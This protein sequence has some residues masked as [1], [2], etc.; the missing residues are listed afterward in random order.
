MKK[1]NYKKRNRVLLY[2]GGMD[3]WLISKIWNPD[4]KLYV[5]LHTRYSNEELKRLPKDVKIVD[6]DLSAWERKD[7]IIPLR[8][9]YLIG[10]ATNFGD[11]ICLGATAGDRVLDK[12][13]KFGE[14]YSNLLTYLYQE[15]HWTKKREIKINLD[16]KELT[17]T[18]LLKTYLAQGGDIKTAFKESFSCYN[19]TNG[20]ECWSCKPCFRK[21]VAFALNGYKFT[22][23]IKTKAISYIKSEILP[24][25]KSGTYGRKAEEEEILQVLKMFNEI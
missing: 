10:I 14:L 23:D 24:A 13:I 9:V 21:F 16:F 2:S 15:Q 19:P 17:K 11:E 25:I 12:S 18:Q 20:C 3:S 8:N 4:V 5:N 22:N 1:D 6:L 7:A